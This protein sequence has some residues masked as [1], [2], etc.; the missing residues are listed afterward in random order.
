MY[1]DGSSM[2]QQSS[3]PVGARERLAQLSSIVR[4]AMIMHIKPW[5]F[6][7]MMGIAGFSGCSESS[8]PIPDN[9]LQILYRSTFRFPTDT[10]G[11]KTRGEINLVLDSLNIQGGQCL[12]FRGYGYE[13]LRIVD[14][15]R[16]ESEL[17]FRYR[18]RRREG[19]N[20]LS[21]V[22][23]MPL[24]LHSQPPAAGYPVESTV[25]TSFADT[26]IFPAGYNVA[27]V[28]GGTGSNTVILVDDIEVIKILR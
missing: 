21:L 19:T 12:E 4:L 15:L 10:L 28:I 2:N 24:E 16:A 20:G 22:L 25:W 1:S 9:N 18:A 13:T 27:V 3:R 26:A 11:W 7:A 5:I 8:E 17:I 14:T 6:V 23:L